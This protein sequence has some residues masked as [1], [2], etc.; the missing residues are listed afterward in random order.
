MVSIGR[1]DAASPKPAKTPTIDI[2]QHTCY[3]NI[4]V[5]LLITAVLGWL[6]VFLPGCGKPQTQP[7]RDDVKIGDLKTLETEKVPGKR[8]LPTANFD[9]HIY[10]LP[11]EKLAK[12]DDLWAGLH[13]RGLTFYNYRAFAANLF[14]I[15]MG[16]QFA[17]SR[18]DDMIKDVG[19]KR[20][21]VISMLLPNGRS[22]D[23]RMTGLD[24]PEEISFID[25]SLLRD[26][27]LI[28]P[29]IVNLRLTGSQ[30]PGIRGAC[31][32]VGYPTFTVPTPSAEGPMAELA[33]Q[34][35]VE[36]KA[37]GFGLKMSPD[38]FIVLGPTKYLSERVSLGGLFFTNLD[39]TVFTPRG[40][41]PTRRTSVR[42]FV[43][44]CTAINYLQ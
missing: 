14:R 29:G 2:S 1:I 19:G 5:R 43:L 15:G 6:F 13:S 40:K 8:S 16:R 23:L 11:A 39:G 33:K 41:R 10:E 27:V 20:M 35:E 7:F 12:L 37:A 44:V 4:M 42:I 17:W 31:Q 32:I 3:N 9:V 28:G 22:E 34:N 24:R 36:F 25:R 38:E 18:I 26:K 30:V 21:A